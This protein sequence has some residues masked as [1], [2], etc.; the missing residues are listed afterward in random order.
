[1]GVFAQPARRAF[2]RSNSPGRC[3]RQLGQETS[4]SMPYQRDPACCFALSPITT[5]APK[6]VSSHSCFHSPGTP[7][8]QR[9][10][11]QGLHS[12]FRTRYTKNQR[13]AWDPPLCRLLGV[14]FFVFFD[15]LFQG[16]DGQADAVLFLI[17]N[18]NQPPKDVPVFHFQSLREGLSPHEIGQSHGG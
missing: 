14:C 11:R 1:M 12:P 2:S 9:H 10:S 16:F 15:G 17:R 13:E 4:R 5:K 6:V 18:L 3:T 8:G 7:A